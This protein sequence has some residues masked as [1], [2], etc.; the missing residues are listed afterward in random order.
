MLGVQ[1]LPAMRQEV[2]D[3]MVFV[4]GQT[5]QH[6][7]QIFVRVMPVEL[8]ALNQTY[9]SRCP[10]PAARCPVRSKPANNQLPR[11]NGNRPNLVLNPVVVDRQAPVVNKPA[12]CHPTFQAVV[13]RFGSGRPVG[14]ALALQ[15]H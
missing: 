11:P 14:D 10:L 6:I 1:R 7:F 15:H 12:Q 4:C 2:G 9:H 13:Q 8:G 3:Q 5:L